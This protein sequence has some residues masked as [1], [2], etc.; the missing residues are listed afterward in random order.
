MWEID[1][2][3]CRED[4]WVDPV[5]CQVRDARPLGGRSDDDRNSRMQRRTDKRIAIT[6]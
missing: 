3:G 4:A 5:A 6:E 2:G 1:G